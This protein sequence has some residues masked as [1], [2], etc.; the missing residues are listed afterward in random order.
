VTPAITPS[1]PF[2]GFFG[3][4]GGRGGGGTTVQQNF[5]P[6]S[7][8][9]SSL[10]PAQI[11]GAYGYSSLF[12]GNNSG[13][14]NTLAGKGTTIAIIDAYVDPTIVNDV[15]KFSTQYHLPQLDGAGGDPTLTVTALGSQVDTT[16]GWELET[17]LDV[18]WAHAIAP[19]A[20]ILLVEA[21]NASTSALLAAVQAADKTPGVVAVSMSWGGPEFGIPA[22]ADAT[23]FSTPGI[24]Y[25]AASGDN[26]AGAEWPASSA[27]VV[28]VGGTNLTVNGSSYVSES[29]W[30][31]SGGG[32][33][34][35][36]SQPPY[37]Q[38]YTGPGSSV[39]TSTRGRG[40][41]DVAFDAS[42][43]NGSGIAVYDSYETI[44]TSRGFFGSTT[45]EQEYNWTQIGGT[46]VGT[47][48]WAATAAI[49][50]GIRLQ[51]P[52]GT[53]LSGGSQFLPALYAIGSSGSY[54]SAFND[55]TTGGNGYAAG[56]GYD[57][58]TG[59]GSPKAAGLVAS[60]A[61][62]TGT[63][64][65]V[66]FAASHAANT[67]VTTSIATPHDIPITLIT[68]VTLPFPGSSSSAPISTPSP[69]PAPTSTQ[70]QPVL[71]TVVSLSPSGAVSVSAIVVVFAPINPSAL[72]TTATPA[73]VHT[74]IATGAESG[75]PGVTVLTATTS[76]AVRVPQPLD[77]RPAF[78]RDL[79][80]RLRDDEDPFAPLDYKPPVP[81]WEFVGRDDLLDGLDLLA[82]AQHAMALGRVAD[83]GDAGAP[84]PLAP[85]PA[86]V[87]TDL[88]QRDAT[89]AVDPAMAGVVV[90]V[91]GVLAVK[92]SRSD[93][94]RRP[95]FALRPGR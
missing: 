60:L 73:P 32:P 85:P 58:A 68:I 82:I 43:S 84:A 12:A 5:G 69:T 19:A 91:G 79:L 64:T 67:A 92:V 76:T 36:V 42:P 24:T 40:T 57:F 62:V 21:A 2:G 51:V 8:L 66:K 23:Y 93:A 34:R 10:T 26:G 65:G 30:S 37:Q 90:A 33:S 31:D 46:S 41:P 28:G 35:A 6:T 9:S 77:A 18:E 4:F 83:Q 47:P 16:G 81:P 29:A 74:A 75:V 59:L 72:S 20:N 11:Q 7:P 13:T 39:L 78:D 22:N 70:T 86:V 61:S 14:Y 87:P 25:F 80:L 89:A 88:N 63:G 44:T 27:S 17:A 55:I 52:N 48:A 56:T 50:D 15:S 54:S 45:Y 3:G 95:W 94:R 71:V 38:S 49:A 53:S 1:F